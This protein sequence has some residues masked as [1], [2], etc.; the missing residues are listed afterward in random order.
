MTKHDIS[1]KIAQQADVDQVVAKQI[2][3]MTLDAMIEALATE[4]RLELRNFGVFE[5]RVS[6]ARK[7]RN[8]KTGAEVSV[9]EGRRVKFEAGKMMAERVASGA[10]AG[11]MNTAAP[12]ANGPIATA[13]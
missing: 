8:P 3:Q 12:V 11:A 1:L 2:V 13:G 4:G 5:V 9:P 10:K 7:A 6:K